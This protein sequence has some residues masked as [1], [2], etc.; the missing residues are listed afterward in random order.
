MLFVKIFLYENFSYSK[1][2][3]EVYYVICLILTTFAFY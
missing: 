3:G 1:I 2:L